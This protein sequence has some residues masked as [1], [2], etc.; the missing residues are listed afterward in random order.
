MRRKFLKP[1]YYGPK[2]H[3]LE[4]IKIEHVYREFNASADALANEALNIVGSDPQ[5]QEAVVYRGWFL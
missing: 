3:P 2:H 4:R 5:Q 1:R